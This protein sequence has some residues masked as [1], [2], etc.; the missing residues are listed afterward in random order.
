MTEEIAYLTAEIAELAGEISVSERLTTNPTLKRRNRIKTVYSSL[1]IEQNAL[2]IDQV[3][4]VIN[5]KRILAPPAD[6][7]E[8]RNAYEIYDRLDTLDPCSIDDLLHAH[9]TMMKDLIKEAGRFRTGNVGVYSGDVLIH[10]GTPAKYVPEVVKELFVWLKYSSLH[11]IVKACV[12]HY[13]FEFIHPFAD[14]NGRIGRLWHALILSKWKP[15]FAWVPVESLIY[16][17]QQGYYD[18]LGA[19][20]DRGNMNLFVSLMLELLKRALIEIKEKP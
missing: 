18:A 4:D 5:G 8:V 19:A 2:T 7:K 1:A 10:A 12:F 17:D 3:T 15:F 6:I 11:P 14:G 13:E 9:E 16:D 20:N